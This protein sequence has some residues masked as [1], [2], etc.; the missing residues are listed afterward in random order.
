VRCGWHS[1]QVG[2]QGQRHDLEV[3]CGGDVEAR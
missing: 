3:P 1:V 2:S